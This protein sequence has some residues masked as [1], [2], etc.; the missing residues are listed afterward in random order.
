MGSPFKMGGHTLPGPNQKVSPMKA[1]LSALAVGLI[2]A[3]VTAAVGTGTAAI[4]AAQKKKAA[5][6]KEKKDKVVA[7][8]VEASESLDQDLGTETNITT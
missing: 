5:E 6:K 8:N 1:P 3:G 7:A 2:S 4:S